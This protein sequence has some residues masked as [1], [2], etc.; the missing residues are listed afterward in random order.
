MLSPQL[1][2]NA[3]QAAPGLAV[4]FVTWQNGTTKTVLLY[5]VA[6]LVRS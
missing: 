6:G 1:P 2:T 5:F 3:A 4:F